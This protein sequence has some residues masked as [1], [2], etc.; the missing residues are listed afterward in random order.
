[1]NETITILTEHRSRRKFEASYQISKTELNLILQSA[2]QAP[3]FENGQFY[4]M[5][6]LVDPTIKEKLV[7]LNPG[8]SQIK[9]CSEAILFV[10]DL[11]RTR[12]VS[13]KN[14]TYYDVTNNYDALIMATTDASLACENAVIASE[15]LGYGTVIVGGIRRNSMEIIEL[16]DLPEFCLP[17]FLL[18]I[19]KAT[20]NPEK[21]PRLP[22]EISI[23][24]DRY[25][26]IDYSK[27]CEY[28]ATMK[29]YRDTGVD[30]PWIQKF[31]NFFKSNKLEVTE[32]ALRKQKFIK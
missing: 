6:R 2:K 21:K 28:D 10:A 4:S 7:R 19:G 3:S 24:E 31:V 29:K 13:E 8:N 16:C 25:S 32:T 17:L 20:D 5:I 14:Q 27:I 12:T 15:S 23:F 11:N 9:E 1:M 30:R 26:A 22:K 18:C